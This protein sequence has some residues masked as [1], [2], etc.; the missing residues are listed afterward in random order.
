MFS[1]FKKKPPA[2][3]PDTPALPST[4]TPAAPAPA[5][6]PAPTRSVFSPSS[7]FG[8]KPAVEETPSAPPPAPSLPP[9]PPPPQPPPPP[10]APPAPVA[11]PVPAPAPA[12]APFFAPPPTP[13]AAPVVTPA[14]VVAAP[15]VAPTPP[16]TR[17][18]HRH[19]P[20][21]RTR[22][23]RAARPGAF[24]SPLRP[25]YGAPVP[26]P[27]AEPAVA[28]ERKSWLD[29]LKTACARPAPASRPC[30]STR[31]STMRCMKSSNPPC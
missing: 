5:P 16:A 10:A 15:V 29:K 18:R 24:A 4:G 11:A 30:S 20:S 2:E 8:S 13:V 25:R 12:P 3:T 22:V 14:P 1:F 28:T 21:T 31:R 17:Y 23:R 27:I 9:P 26:A 7:W 6:E 19:Q